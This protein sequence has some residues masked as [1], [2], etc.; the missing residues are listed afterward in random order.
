[1]GFCLYDIPNGN[2]FVCEDLIIE[3][4][5]HWW[6][7]SKRSLS[8]L[9]QSFHSLRGVCLLRRVILRKWSI[10]QCST[11][12]II[13]QAN[14]RFCFLFAFCMLLSNDPIMK[15]NVN[16]IW[17][18]FGGNRIALL[19]KQCFSLWF[20]LFLQLPPTYLKVYSNVSFTFEFLLS[21]RL[22]CVTK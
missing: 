5:N 10:C 8:V 22:D 4:I 21:V 17:R 16:V 20:P 13:H 18:R 15:I 12:I 7:I 19:C 14:H 11:K 6:Y 1:M 9:V 2:Q 3:A